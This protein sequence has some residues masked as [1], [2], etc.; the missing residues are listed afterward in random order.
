MNFIISLL[1]ANSKYVIYNIILVIINQFIK[2]SL[3][4][5]IIKKLT[6]NRL[7]DLFIYYIFK[8]YSILKGIIINKGLLFILGF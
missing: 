8:D 7:A 2:Y 5:P 4:I 1:L 6:S 3:F